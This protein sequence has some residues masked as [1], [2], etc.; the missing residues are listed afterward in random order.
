MIRFN[1]RP[2]I[3]EAWNYDVVI[4]EIEILP[5]QQVRS[6]RQNSLS[7]ANL[8][9]GTF[10]GASSL[11]G[12]AAGVLGEPAA[13]GDANDVASKVIDLFNKVRKKN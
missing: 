2:P 5:G 10:S 1:A 4:D 7:F 11:A 3:G 13:A 8:T 9:P 12:A 6:V